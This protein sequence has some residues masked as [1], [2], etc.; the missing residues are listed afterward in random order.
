SLTESPTDPAT[1]SESTTYQFNATITDP[2]LETVILEF[3]SINY[4]PSSSGNIYTT[5][6][7]NISVGTYNYRWYAN[8]TFGNMNS[9]ESGDYTIDQA[10]PSLSLT[11]TPSTSETYG[12]ETT[13]TSS[14]CSSQ[15]TCNLYRNS[16]SVSKPDIQTLGVGTY[17]YTFN[18]TG[19][20]NYTAHTNTTNLTITQNTGAC[21]VLFNE[22]SPITYPNSFLVYSDCTTTFTLYRNSTTISNNSAQNLGV[23]TYNFTVIRTDQQN[24]S[25]IYDEENFVVQQATGVVYTYLNHSRANKTIE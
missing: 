1:Y 3:D 25:N 24:Y 5:N 7:T 22:T 14:G 19:N 21:N 23:S 6:L 17:N 18:T 11:I 12:T 8:D 2:S 15:L 16:V 10:T 4:T 9:T 20:A 13:A